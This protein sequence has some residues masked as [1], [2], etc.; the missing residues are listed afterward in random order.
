MFT[1]HECQKQPGE[2]M[3]EFIIKDSGKR[4]EFSSGM[5]RDTGDKPRY[6]RIFIGPMAQRWAEH[7]H[8]GSKKYPDVSP[9]VPNWTLAAGEAELQRFKESALDHMVKWLQGMTDEDHAAGV[10]FNVNGAEYVKAKLSA[11][12]EVVEV[13][14]CGDCDAK[15]ACICDQDCLG[16]NV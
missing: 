9:G 2:N 6:L 15:D 10:F 13:H 12:K 8:K 7:L 4:E 11:A 3:S 5:V 1:N 14:C 16:E